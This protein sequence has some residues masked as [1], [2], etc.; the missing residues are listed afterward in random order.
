M[1]AI[2]TTS[3]LSSTQTTFAGQASILGTIGMYSPS[4]MQSLSTSWYRQPMDDAGQST[5]LRDITRLTPKKALALLKE[6][7]SAHELENIR[8][9][10]LAAMFEASPSVAMR[11]AAKHRDHLRRAVAYA[12]TGLPF[13]CPFWPR[14]LADEHPAEFLAKLQEEVARYRSGANIA[15]VHDPQELALAYAG[16]DHPTLLT[17]SDF[18]RNLPRGPLPKLFLTES[19]TARLRHAPMLN[20][21]MDKGVLK[22]ASDPIDHVRL[23][24][25]FPQRLRE[26]PALSPDLRRQ[27]LEAL[28]SG[29]HPWLTEPQHASITKLTRKLISAEMP[30]QRRRSMLIHLIVFLTW[31]HPAMAPHRKDFFHFRD[32]RMS[33]DDFIVATG[34]LEQFYRVW[35]PETM[36]TL[37]IDPKR[38]PFFAKIAARLEEEQHKIAAAGSLESHEELVEFHPSKNRADAYFGHVS[39]DSNKWEFGHIEGDHFQFYR[40]IS[41]GRLMGLLYVGLDKYKTSWLR[42]ERNL[43]IA[44]QPRTFWDV[45]REQL[46]D[47]VRTRFAGLAHRRGYNGLYMMANPHQ[48]SNDPG[49]HQ[50]IAAK[51]L[52]PFNLP[53]SR[54]RINAGVFQGRELLTLWKE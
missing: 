49:I 9:S 27:L 15:D 24:D 28:P 1:V 39:D 52:A 32:E 30:E 20:T 35:I 12:D 14:Y 2:F 8:P 50:A 7:T 51:A 21:V 4:S 3:L 22:A 10:A 17:F 38:F 44:I 16:L 40:I 43:L 34:F 53:E 33:N 37:G 6:V 45:D 26:S 11:E 47:V 48:Q 19:F 5:L 23:P 31:Q 42:T 54:P 46:F 36:S 41:R 25:Q 29:F 18:C 13:D